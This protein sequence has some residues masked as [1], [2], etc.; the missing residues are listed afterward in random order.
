MNGTPPQIEIIAPFKAAFEWMKA[1][2][3]RP[4]D[5]GRWLTIAFAAFIAG[6]TGGSGGGNF[7]RVGQWRN[8]DWKYRMTSHGDWQI[9]PWVVI[10]LIAAIVIFALIVGLILAWVTSRGRFVF[11]DCIVRNRAAIVEPWKEFRREGNSFF[12]FVVIVFFGTLFVLGLLGLVGWGLFMVLHP[13]GEN[14]PGLIVFI[15]VILVLVLI[16]LIASMFVGLIASFMIPVMY[17]RRCGAGEAFRDV[18]RLILANPKP[19]ILFLLFGIALGIAVAIIGTLVACM[20][21]CVG[22]LPYISTVLLLPAIV[23]LAAYRL[24]FIRQF[25]DQYDVW[26]S[27]APASPP[28]PAV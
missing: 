1:M 18:M 13:S 27:A 23:W 14:A 25:G 24:L 20:T 21:C 2:L 16:W 12:L 26:A 17:R 8:Q 22:A 4:F 5:I 6:G 15:G 19:F 9:E 7:G 10:A 28:A 3:F 11:T